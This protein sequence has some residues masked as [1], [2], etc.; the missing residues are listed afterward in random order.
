MGASKDRK[1]QKEETQRRQQADSHLEPQ[2]NKNESKREVGSKRKREKVIVPSNRLFRFI[3]FTKE[4]DNCVEFVRDV[5]HL[6]FELHIVRTCKLC[7]ALLSFMTEVKEK[8]VPTLK[9]EVINYTFPGMKGSKLEP[10]PPSLP[11]AARVKE[12]VAKAPPAAKVVATAVAGVRKSARLHASAEEASQAAAARRALKQLQDRAAEEEEDSESSEESEKGEGSDDDLGEGDQQVCHELLYQGKKIDIGLGDCK[13]AE[14]IWKAL[15]KEFL[16]PLARP[17]L[18]H[19]AALLEHFAEDRILREQLRDPTTEPD[20]DPDEDQPAQ[21]SHQMEPFLLYWKM[22]SGKSEGIEKIISKMP[23]YYTTIICSNSMIGAWVAMT[24][25]HSQVSGTLTQFRVLGF[26]HFAKLANKDLNMLKGHVAI[27]DEAQQWRNSGET[28]VN[29]IEALQRARRVFYLSGTPLVNDPSEIYAWISMFGYEPSTNIKAIEEIFRDRVSFFDPE[30]HCPSALS[31]HFPYI[32]EQVVKVEMSFPQTLDYIFGMG[33]NIFFG[34]MQYCGGSRSAYN[35]NERRFSNMSDHAPWSNKM[36]ELVRR[37]Q[38]STRFPQVVH[39]HF[40]DRGVDGIFTALQKNPVQQQVPLNL[41]TDQDL[42]KE[43][44]QD[45]QLEKLMDRLRSRYGKNQKLKISMKAPLN[46]S[47]TKIRAES[48]EAVEEEADGELGMREERMEEDQDPQS[49]IV[50]P[51]NR[52][53]RGQRLILERITGSTQTGERYKIM[54]E[55]NKGK[56]NLLFISDAAHEGLDLMETA[57]LYLFEVHTSLQSQAQTWARTV[58][59]N[60][61]LKSRGFLKIYQFLSVFPSLKRCSQMTTAEKKEIQTIMAHRKP[62]YD[63]VKALIEKIQE[64]GTTIEERLYENNLKKQ[65]RINP[66]L[67][68]M[69]YCSIGPTPEVIRTAYQALLDRGVEEF[70]MGDPDQQP[71]RQPEQKKGA[72]QRNPDHPKE[73]DEEWKAEG[74]ARAPRQVSKGKR[75]IRASEEEQEEE[76]EETPKM[77]KI[78]WNR[79]PKPLKPR[80][81][82]MVAPKPLSLSVRFACSQPAPMD[83]RE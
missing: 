79:P 4:Q 40:R 41:R 34:P 38:T 10:L 63:V 24:T 15:R 67:L 53:K 43:R 57:V 14:E 60:S 62:D 83:L 26:T 1:A 45:A 69:Q 20:Q 46:K 16:V 77:M 8:L 66:I 7:T 9:Y 71:R 73:K 80:T 48:F 81:V 51:L 27:V 29:C 23:P 31:N 2:Q 6:A 78:L 3:L 39:S 61:H 52:R 44:E 50:T 19:Q 55:Y 70:E 72:K 37:I 47:R 35:V 54:N 28:S 59:Y 65:E 58:R 30:I 82:P 13:N 36:Q 75:G 5:A 42:I 64:L 49:T 76:P 12:Q 56:I 17:A 18:P 68:L 25:A 74:W 21:P 22:G 32:S 11:A 33:Q